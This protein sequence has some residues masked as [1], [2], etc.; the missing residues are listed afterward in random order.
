MIRDGA[1]GVGAFLLPGVAATVLLAGPAHAQNGRLR[2][3]IPAQSLATALNQFAIQTR[4]PLIY[5]PQAVSGRRTRG[6]EG[7]Y[8][9]R[10]ALELL[11]ADTDLRVR[12]SPRGAFLIEAAA[13]P[14]PAPAVGPAPPPSSP[15]L[16]AAAPESAVVEALEV[17]GSYLRDSADLPSPVTVLTREE[18]AKTSRTSLGEFL[19]ADPAFSGSE[20]FTSFGTGLGNSSAASVNLRGLGNRATL[21]LL[22]GRRSVDSA[23]PTRDGYVTFDINSILPAIAIARV[24]VLKDGASAQYGSDAVAGVVNFLTRDDFEGLELKTSARRIAVSG[25]SEW[26]ASG[27]VGARSGRAHVIAAAEYLRRDP[28]DYLSF[29]EVADF[30]ARNGSLSNFGSPGSFRL[31]PGQVYNASVPAGAADRLVRDPLCGDPR[32][33]SGNLAGVPSFIGSPTADQQVCLLDATLS[34]AVIAG[35]RRFNSFVK[36]RYEVSDRLAL[37]LEAGYS[38]E[39]LV[40]ADGFGN[41]QPELR[42]PASNPYNPFGGDVL[43]RGRILGPTAGPEDAVQWRASSN[44]RRLALFAD[45]RL[46]GAHGWRWNGA[47]TVSR[48]ESTAA[49]L[50]VVTTR[51]ANALKGLGGPRCDPAT[52]TPGMGSCSY[53]NP[54]A[55]QYLDRPNDSALYDDLVEPAPSFASGDLVT[56]TATASGPLLDLPAG[57]LDLALGY[58][59]RRSTLKIDY[60]PLV[61]AG[62]FAFTGQ[63][64]PL[65]ATRS[66][67]SLFA[68]AAAPLAAGLSLQLAARY[69]S[70]GRGVDALTPKVGA[71]WRPARDLR[72]RAAFGKSFKA[73]GLVPSYGTIPAATNQI[74]VPGIIAPL[75]QTLTL[76]NPELQPE[77]ATTYTLGATWEP[78][79]GLSVSLDGWRYDFV[80]IIGQESPT[81]L[82]QDYVATGRYADRLTFDASN[83]LRRIVLKFNN[84]SA[85]RTAGLDFAVTWLLPCLRFGRFT[86]ET[87]GSWTR[88]YQYRLRDDQP[89]KD[90]VGRTNES[91]FVNPMPEFK[92]NMA[93]DWALAAH[94]AR[95]TL[96]YI[97]G[98]YSDTIPD[99]DPRQTNRGYLQLDLVYSYTFDLASGPVNVQ[100]GIQNLND[101]RPPL[102]TGLQPALPGVYDPRGRVFSLDIVKRF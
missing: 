46:G 1:R 29:P 88:K 40:R 3:S 24:D 47:V 62:D 50:D 43:F 63:P 10:R 25:D 28:F 31:I 91:T 84:F 56:A 99:N 64:T 72:V 38:H 53:W 36:A 70:Y 102:L 57:P 42:V 100:A 101:A 82:V 18:L 86:W 16:A 81:L 2:L 48:N 59:H 15:S 95:A 52:G 22:N 74:N 75:P 17:T 78:L 87:R 85:L 32:L 76:P 71:L 96:R 83:E 26:L 49:R 12:T 13:P 34:R 77:R 60:S 4:A 90:G 41:P 68:E 5:S 97:S 14:P 55:T 20:V 54:F 67:H 98:M 89:A 27:I 45:G 69:E 65:D 7:T 35:A 92:V 23:Q 8:T 51:F 80:D 58:E 33:G 9:A 21:I 11:L 6:V 19:H 93:L 61:L 30:A 44:T 79:R 37:G 66:V 73:P 94:S 39:S